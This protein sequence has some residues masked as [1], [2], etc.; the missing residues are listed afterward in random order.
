M[1]IHNFTKKMCLH[2]ISNHANFHQN[3]SINEFA[4]KVVL[5][6]L[7]EQGSYFI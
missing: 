6:D 4:K 5:Y 1:V 2:D 7:D 3:R